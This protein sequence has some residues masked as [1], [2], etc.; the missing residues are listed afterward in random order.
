MTFAAKQAISAFLAP[1]ARRFEELNER[2][3]EDFVS[4][5]VVLTC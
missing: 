3:S 5:A 1:F 4:R 2:G